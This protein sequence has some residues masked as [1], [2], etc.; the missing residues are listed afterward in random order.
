MATFSW[1]RG[2]ERFLFFCLKRHSPRK[3]LGKVKGRGERGI[4]GMNV[5]GV[6]YMH[7]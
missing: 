6:H 5:I 3:V 7:I 2:K 4:K 1:W